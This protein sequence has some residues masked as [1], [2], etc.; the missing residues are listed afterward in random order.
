[1]TVT[2]KSTVESIVQTIQTLPESTQLA[3]LAYVDGMA[4][5]ADHQRLPKADD[6][7]KAP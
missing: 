3:L 6:H 5:M 2:D 7:Q 4:A 1:M